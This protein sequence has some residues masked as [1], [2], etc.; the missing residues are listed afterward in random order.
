MSALDYNQAIL[1]AQHNNTTEIQMLRFKY[2]L[3]NDN[4]KW[5]LNHHLI[6]MGNNDL[7]WG[8][9]TLYHNFPTTGHAGGRK[10]LFAINQDYW[11]PS[12]RRDVADFV[13]GCA[14]CQSTKPRT[15]Q[16][17]P[18]LYP[19][20]TEPNALPFETI[21][22]DFITKLPK[23]EGNNTILTITDQA[24]SKAAFFIPC[25]ETI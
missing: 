11:W 21:T 17:K 23:S 25:K 10:T 3:T 22:L 2:P 6:V 14:T 13:K 18:P 20:T 8:V 9:I 24:C 19:I 15:T 12:M 7:K 16:P 5:T 4:N 1:N